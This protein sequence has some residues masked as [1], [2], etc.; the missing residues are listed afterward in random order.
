M[1]L[2]AYTS[3]QAQP[4]HMSSFDSIK[5]FT[6]KILAE[7]TIRILQR[8]RQNARFVGK[9]LLQGIMAGYNTEV[10]KENVISGF[11]NSGL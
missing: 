6:I 8:L 11:A 5:N 1:A 10:S 2:P 3:D 7:L 9:D 4:L